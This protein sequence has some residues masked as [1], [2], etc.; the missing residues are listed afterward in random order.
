M[1]KKTVALLLA[2]VLV[3]GVAAGG[4]LAW[5]IDK[6]DPVVNT[7][8]YGDIDI[9]LTETVP[10]GKQAKI[11]PGV[12]IPKDPKVIVEAGS[13]KCWL[14]VKAV[15]AGDFDSNVSYEFNFDNT[16]TQGDGTDG[17]PTDVWYKVVDVSNSEDNFELYLLKGD[18]TNPNG[19]V[20]VSGDLTKADVAKINTDPTL[21]FQAAAVQWDNRDLAQAWSLVRS[22]LGYPAPIT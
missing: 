16:W 8:T 3:L 1:K 7:F 5:L 10:E 4:T 15:A 9:K 22:D 18:A 12:D 13:E 6:T 21:T 19:V 14:F 2:L 20:H 17:I 11:I